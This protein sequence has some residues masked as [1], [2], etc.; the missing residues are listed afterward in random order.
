MK[1]LLAALFCIAALLAGCSEPK[2][3]VSTDLSM[4]DWGK[5]FSLTNHHGKPARLAD[6]R[7]KAVVMFFGYTQCPDVCPTTLATLRE[8]MTL[9]GDDASRV[10]VLFVSVDPA[11]DTPQLLAQ[12]VP[13]FHPSFLGV[14]ADDKATAALAKDFKVFYARQ[15][16]TTPGSYSIDHSTGSYVFDPQGKLRLLLRH[17]ES[18]ANV[19]A[20]LKLLLAG[21]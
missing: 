12:Y 17:G 8:T 19:A 20:D 16:G 11:R 2:R 18:P 3:F 9:L 7:G 1:P 5:D 13:A 15:P 21:K 10:Q 6:F 14:Y 4:V